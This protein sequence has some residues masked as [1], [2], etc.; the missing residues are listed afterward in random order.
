MTSTISIGEREAERVR[1]GV[2]F[3]PGEIIANRYRIRRLIGKGGMG[4]VY[5]VEDR[6]L[7]DEIVALKTTLAPPDRNGLALKRFRREVQFARRV[8]NIHTCRTYDVGFDNRTNV[9]FVTMEYI[10]GETLHARLRGA[11]R[12]SHREGLLIAKQI[13]A[14]IAAAHEVGVIHRDIKSANIMLRS[15]EGRLRAIVTDFGLARLDADE[16]LESLTNSGMLV[17]TPAYMAPEQVEGGPITPAADI[18]AIGIVMFEI[19]TGRLPFPASTPIAIAMRRLNEPAPSPRAF[20]TR[21]DPAWEAVIL[22]CLA[23]RPEDRYENAQAL[24]RALEGIR[25]ADSL[26][27]AIPIK[28]AP[29][30]ARWRVSLFAGAVIATLLSVIISQHP[31]AL[32]PLPVPVH[33][34]VGKTESNQ[35]TTIMTAPPTQSVE[36]NRTAEE[37]VPDEPMAKGNRAAA[38]TTQKLPSLRLTS[39]EGQI[40]DSGP[41]TPLNASW[42][43]KNLR[44]ARKRPT[45]LVFGATWCAPFVHNLQILDDIRDQYKSQVL[46]IGLL[47]ELDELGTPSTRE[48]VTQMTKPNDFKLHYLLKDSSIQRAIFGK[49][50][51]PLPA[52]A[53]FD[54]NDELVATVVGSL[55]S[56]ETAKFLRTALDRVSGSQ[57][58][59]D[60]KI[61]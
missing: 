29:R 33:D 31:L 2:T 19:V 13:A 44:V 26:V 7:N 15:Q 50:E 24:A 20:A 51:V 48:R 38:T 6:E 23:R 40:K 60:E 16:G 27:P 14:G 22:R 11:K 28:P 30:R 35:T 52:F 18:Y 57:Q 47:D 1:C 4:A 41:W 12:P 58:P 25:G 54:A 43:M 49:E 55:S 3:V 8:T 61:R 42:F 21:L 36:P 17:G 46:F 9:V 59:T 32:K 53:L 45:L 5:E 39:I 56:P 34:R 10:E 37:N